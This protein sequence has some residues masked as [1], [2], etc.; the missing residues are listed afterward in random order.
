MNSAYQVDR[1]RWARF[2][3]FE[4]MGNIGSEIGRTFLAGRRNDSEGVRNAMARA[5]D[6]FEATVE[7][8]VKVKSP[9]TK[10]V[11]RAK[12]QFLQIV[13]NQTFHSAQAEGL[14]RYFMAFALAARA[15][16]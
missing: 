1:D 10:E 9:R 7:T 16:R 13:S 5:L 3:I 4:Q 14:E 12:D 6:L 8:L 11:L 15:S 2:T